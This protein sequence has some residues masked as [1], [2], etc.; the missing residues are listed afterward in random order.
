MLLY[1]S[2]TVVIKLK[3]KPLAK[4][5]K[6]IILSDNVTQALNEFNVNSTRS[7]LQNNN[8]GTELDRIII[9]KYNSNQDPFS[10]PSS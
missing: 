10:L 3:A 9:V 7:F 1:M 6:S 2:N 4:S 8:S 5:D